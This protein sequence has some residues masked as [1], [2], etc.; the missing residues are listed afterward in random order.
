MIDE[1]IKHTKEELRRIETHVNK[2]KEN[3]K[4]PLVTPSTGLVKAILK[5]KGY[6]V[7]K[8]PMGAWCVYR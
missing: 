4:T 6:T 7:Y 3:G 2:V 5:L 8:G 1:I